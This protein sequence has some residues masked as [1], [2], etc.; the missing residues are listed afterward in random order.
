[1][2]KNVWIALAIVSLP[3]LAKAQFSVSGKINDKKA[4]SG[5]NGAT[6]L[7]LKTGRVVQST[8]SGA[9]QL[10]DLKAGK[11]TLRVEYQGYK[12]MQQKL[13]V[14]KDIQI[15]FK[16][17]RIAVERNN[18]FITAM[19]ATEKATT[20][21]P[22]AVTINGV[23]AFPH[24]SQHAYFIAMPDFAYSV[25]SNNPLQRGIGIA[26]N[27][28]GSFGAFMNVQDV[29]RNDDAYAELNNTYGSLNTWRT[30]LKGGT[31][32]I[33]NKFTV[34]TRL[35]YINSNGYISSGSSNI[36]SGFVSGAY[37][38]AKSLLRTNVFLGTEQTNENWIGVKV[39][40]AFLANRKDNSLTYD[41][42]TDNYLQSHYQL[43]YGY[44]FSNKVSLSSAAHY[45]RAFGFYEENPFGAQRY[46]NYID[47]LDDYSGSLIR[48]RSLDTDFYGLASAVTYVPQ[49]DLKYTVGGS[50]GRY[51]GSHFGDLLWAQNTTINKP[52]KYTNDDAFKAVYAAF[53]QTNYQLG[54]LNLSAELQL[55][56]VEY[57]FSGVNGVLGDLQQQVAINAINPR[58]GA[59][60]QLSS[61]DQLV[62]S[63]A[64]SNMEPRREHYVNSTPNNRPQNQQLGNLR[65]GY[66]T[67]REKLNLNVTAFGMVYKNQLV[68]LG[69][70]NEVGEWLDY[71]VANS[72]R[73]GV[74]LEGKV[75]ILPQLTW[76]ATA[77]LS[78]NRIAEFVDPQSGKSY[79]NTIIAASPSFV[80]ASELTFKPFKKAEI[81]VINRYLGRQFRDNTGNEQNSIN[82]FFVND[83][84]LSYTTSFKYLK[85][86]GVSVLVNNLFGAVY[87][88]N[89]ANYNYVDK[90]FLVNKDY[91]LPQ[92][93]QK[94]NLLFGLNVK[95]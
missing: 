72:S 40:D 4:D 49:K 19:N 22:Q 38:G 43:I 30:S 27:G 23:P 83:L 89:S 12:P 68:P 48:R 35:S 94:Q 55:R 76:Y 60:Y 53:A 59:N 52:L 21:A 25:D 79:T 82:P 50:Y 1:M 20:N 86:V 14:N 29:A 69:R 75:H 90:G 51:K 41:G 13:N 24:E 93:G 44:S 16:L 71:N 28:S 33:N 45:S 8:A 34:D 92:A 10:K 84:R 57:T 36:R 67:Q 70:V 39:N 61:K 80:A 17:E 58:L 15:D 91:F 37:H 7:V 64:I 78:R 95:F 87:D 63:V 77:V 88:Q 5:L 54:K 18:A 85:N 32:L 42:Q 2:K 26:D 46:K 47:E 31:G 9:Y 62:A 6:V 65:V 3:S 74:E 81:A 56:R 11:Y 73:V 66:A